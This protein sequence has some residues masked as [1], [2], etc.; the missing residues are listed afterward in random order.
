MTIRLASSLRKQ[1]SFSISRSAVNRG[2]AAPFSGSFRLSASSSAA[3]VTAS[4]YTA[5]RGFGTSSITP[6]AARSNAVSPFPS[7]AQA[8]VTGMPRRSDRAF[9]LT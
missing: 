4:G 1:A 6:F 2:F 5:R 9:R 7:R 8:P 3:C